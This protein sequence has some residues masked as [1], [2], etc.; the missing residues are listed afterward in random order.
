MKA[1]ELNNTELKGV[2]GGLPDCT[3]WGP[4]GLAWPH[5]GSMLVAMPSSEETCRIRCCDDFNASAYG[6]MLPGASNHASPSQ[7]FPSY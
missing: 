3:C 7:C 2:Y 4:A 5:G 1:K 6:W